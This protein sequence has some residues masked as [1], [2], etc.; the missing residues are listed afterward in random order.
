ML[1]RRAQLFRTR[2]SAEISESDMPEFLSVRSF[3]PLTWVVEDFVQELPQEFAHGGGAT[4]W[5][6]SYLS[7]VNGTAD[8]LDSGEEH[9]LS[10][11][12]SD[13]NVHTLFL[14]ATGRYQLQDLSRVAWDELTPEFREEVETLRRSILQNLIARRF[15]GA[16]MTGRSLERALRFIVQALQKGMFHDLPSLWS[17]WSQQVAEMSLNDADSWFSSLLQ[18]IDTDEDPLNVAVFNAQVEEA[19]G[20]SIGFYEDL[21]RDFAVGL[22]LGNFE[23]EWQRTLSRRSRTIMSVSAVGWVTTSASKRTT[24][25]SSSRR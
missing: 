4:A 5:L 1:A 25:Q 24:F 19:R 22:R 12:Y 6:K 17:T 8:G 3:P 20:K 15:E 9:F 11:L 13:L 21:L 2:S 16:P 23:T 10:K 14:P 7:K 18:H